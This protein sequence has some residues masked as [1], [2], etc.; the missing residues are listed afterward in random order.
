MEHKEDRYFESLKKFWEM[1]VPPRYIGC[2]KWDSVKNGDRWRVKGSAFVEALKRFT[3]WL[4]DVPRPFEK[5]K[6]PVAHTP[7]PVRG[8]ETTAEGG[9]TVVRWSRK[10]WEDDA[11][12][13][14]AWEGFKFFEV[15]TCDHRQDDGEP[16]GPS[17]LGKTRENSLSV[18]SKR[19]KKYLCVRAVSKYRAKGPWAVAE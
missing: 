15:A 8:I 10:I 18:P 6:R 5:R 2:A 1:D 13:W 16:S 12:E 4:P 17:S 7:P 9:K 19:L 11:V 14:P 3:A